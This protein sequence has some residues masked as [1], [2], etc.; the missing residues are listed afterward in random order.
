M[1]EGD[2]GLPMHEGANEE[3]FVE[4]D[5]K[6]DGEEGEGFVGGSWDLEVEPEVAVHF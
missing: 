4:W 3:V 5:P 1:E 6:G 2:G